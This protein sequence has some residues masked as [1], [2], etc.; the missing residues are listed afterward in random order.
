MME[1]R[2]IKM[3]KSIKI[4]IVEAYTVATELRNARVPL[5]F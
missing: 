1:R 5:S 4:E 3:A 2:T